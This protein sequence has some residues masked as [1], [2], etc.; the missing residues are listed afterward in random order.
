MCDI[1]PLFLQ[2]SSLEEGTVIEPWGD[3]VRTHRCADL[4]REDIGREV[5]IAGWMHSS[6]DHGGVIFIDLRDRDGITQLVFNPEN[7]AELH[8]RA[9]DIRGEWVI[10]VKGTVRERR[11]GRR[12]AAPP[13]WLRLRGWPFR[14]HGGAS[15][16]HRLGG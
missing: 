6:R 15:L 8:R 13:L 10:A 5:L 14:R 11:R 7:D 3:K 2:E 9:G 4:R 1:P 12:Q 16:P